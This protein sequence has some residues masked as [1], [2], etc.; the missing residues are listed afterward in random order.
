MRCAICYKPFYYDIGFN[1]LGYFNF[2]CNECKKTIELKN[3]EIPIDDGYLIYYYY[4]L[5][6]NEY[7]ESLNKRISKQIIDLFISNKNK[8][9]IFLDED[10][11]PYLKYLEMCQNILLYSTVYIDLSIYYEDE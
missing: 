2:I 9:I 3:V 6:D 4:F 10:I 7:E 5:L 8:I 11:I 1:D